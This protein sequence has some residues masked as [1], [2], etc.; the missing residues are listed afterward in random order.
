MTALADAQLQLIFPQLKGFMSPIHS[1]CHPSTIR[2]MSGCAWK[3]TEENPPLTLWWCL[4]LVP[5]DIQPLSYTLTQT[6]YFV[7][8]SDDSLAVL[9]WQHESSSLSLWTFHCCSYTLSEA[10]LRSESLSCDKSCC[11]LLLTVFR[12][13]RRD[14]LPTRQVTNSSNLC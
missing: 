4:W 13:S 10:C 2:Q 6:P 5:D 14:K 11:W 3:C 9:K 12:H 7:L 1:R 8:G